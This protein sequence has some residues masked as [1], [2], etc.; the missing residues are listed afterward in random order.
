MIKNFTIC[1][2]KIKIALLH[3]L[4]KQP[5]VIAQPSDYCCVSLSC[6]AGPRRTCPRANVTLEWIRSSL[7]LCSYLL[8]RLFINLLPS[9]RL[10]KEFSVREQPAVRNYWEEQD[11]RE[12]GGTACVAL[13]LLQLPSHP[14]LSKFK[15]L[16]WGLTQCSPQIWV[17]VGSSSACVVMCWWHL[18]FIIYALYHNKCGEK[19]VAAIKIYSD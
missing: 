16:M 17:R 6:S 8:H 2:S 13:V 19:G 5:S 4:L 10:G 14:P 11:G 15:H 7:Q 9:L 12:R 18:L 1:C 3:Q